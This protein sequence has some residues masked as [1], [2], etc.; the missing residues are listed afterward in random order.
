MPQTPARSFMLGGRGTSTCTW[1]STR[2][3]ACPTRRR[4]ACRPRRT[5]PGI[6]FAF[7][8][9]G[10]SFLQNMSLRRLLPVLDLRL[11]IALFSRRRARRL[12]FD[13]ASK[14]AIPWWMCP[15]MRRRRSDQRHRGALV[16]GAWPGGLRGARWGQW[17]ARI[18]RARK[19]AR[20]SARLLRSLIARRRTVFKGDAARENRRHDDL[21]AVT[22]AEMSWRAESRLDRADGRPSSRRIRAALDAGEDPNQ[23]ART[24]GRFGVSPSARRRSRGVAFLASKE[25]TSATDAAGR[26]ALHGRIQPMAPRP[27]SSALLAAGADSRVADAKALR[28]AI[29]EA[30]ALKAK[31]API[32]KIFEG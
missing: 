7:T 17:S 13:A 4:G 5:S 1:P 11:A 22:R 14:P 3:R 26:T 20:C 27:R 30:K 28:A 21:R 18:A 23:A 12:S 24:A 16:A 31:A 10:R 6:G 19:R 2:P 9:A 15:R 29:A 8:I 25:P 32:L